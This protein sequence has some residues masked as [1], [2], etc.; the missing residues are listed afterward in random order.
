MRIALRFPIPIEE[1]DFEEAMDT[2]LQGKT[3]IMGSRIVTYIFPRD[4]RMLAARAGIF[5]ELWKPESKGI[6]K[7]HQ[8]VLPLRAAMLLLE[9]EPAWFHKKQTN[10]VHGYNHFKTLVSAF[11]TNCERY[12]NA[13]L[14]FT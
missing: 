12:P 5:E 13:I 10:Q 14:D 8:L 11:L 1:A 9:Q 2:A 6:T 7:A 3:E 4:Y